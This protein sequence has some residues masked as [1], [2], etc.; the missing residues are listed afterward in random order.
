MKKSFSVLIIAVLIMA[1]AAGTALAAD[2]L[3]WEQIETSYSDLILTDTAGKYP[4]SFT[5][6]GLAANN[7]CLLL[8]VEGLYADPA[9]IVLSTETAI[10]YIDQ[11]VTAD[12]TVTFS[13]FIPMYVTDSTVVISDGTKRIV[14]YI[15]GQGYPVSGTVSFQ[16]NATDP[17]VTLINNQ[18]IAKVYMATVADVT[19][20][21]DSSYT[22][23]YSFSSI[24]ALAENDTYTLMITKA[25]HLVYGNSLVS[26]TA[27]SNKALG[28]S[29]LVCGDTDATNDIAYEDLMNVLNNYGNTAS[30][31]S[32]YDIDQS[33]DI[34]YEDLMLVLNFYNSIGWSVDAD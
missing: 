5:V 13:D 34:V 33:G 2:Q 24:P 28:L 15:E 10:T 23:S 12:G 11:E 31:V 32:G 21:S 20:N 6:S 7:Q 19:R 16:G 25:G 4:G 8:V 3:T 9:D 14:G 29:S 1:F 30:G 26:V 18:D 27:S 22:G 17:V